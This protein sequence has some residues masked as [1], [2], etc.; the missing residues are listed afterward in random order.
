MCSW[1]SPVT[2]EKG[3]HSSNYSPF[4][5]NGSHYG[6]LVFQSLRNGFV[7]LSR[8]IDVHD[9]VSS[10]PSSVP[11]FPQIM[12]LCVAFKFFHFDRFC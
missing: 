8:L 2:P 10:V 5:D 6:S 7:T 1:S 9:L 4:L 12:A 11:E 3:L